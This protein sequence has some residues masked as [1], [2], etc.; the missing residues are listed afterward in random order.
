[1]SE[2]FFDD[3]HFAQS[4]E[5]SDLSEFEV[6]SDRNDYTLGNQLRS[7]PSSCNNNNNNE[8]SNDTLKKIEDLIRGA[9]HSRESDP[10]GYAESISSGYTRMMDN[11]TDN[12]VDAQEFHAYSV[13]DSAQEP[14]KSNAKSIEFN[15]DHYADSN[16]PIRSTPDILRKTSYNN[17]IQETS[18]DGHAPPDILQNV[19]KENEAEYVLDDDEVILDEKA[20]EW[21]YI[22]KDGS[23]EEVGN[24]VG[25]FEKE[26]QNE[27]GRI[28]SGYNSA[29][30]P[31]AIDHSVLQV[32]QETLACLKS[33]AEKIERLL[34][35]VGF[36]IYNL[37]IYFSGIV[38]LQISM[39]QT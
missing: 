22:G 39:M 36:Y 4:S 33:N 19:V 7:E 18:S 11:S 35:K 25:D 20:P 1:M 27:L 34:K 13:L 16:D 17:R 28:V 5:D 31:A 23:V 38:L 26:V 2:H 29:P 30:M 10:H 6:E 12:A 37:H 14:N 8:E 9:F 24:I 32:Q 15:S 21:I 3:H